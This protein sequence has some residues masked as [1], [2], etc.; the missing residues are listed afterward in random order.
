MPPPTSP[1]CAPSEPPIKNGMKIRGTLTI[2]D[3][4]QH[5]YEFRAQ[6]TTGESTQRVISKSGDA[7]LYETTGK[8]PMMVAHLTTRA[9]SSD[10]VSD[11]YD[12]LD[13]ISKTRD[14]GTSTRPP[15]SGRTLLAEENASVVLSKKERRVR[16]QLCIDLDKTPDYQNELIRLMQKISQCFLINQR[17]L[18]QQLN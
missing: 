9:D 16:M 2:V 13:K 7:K 10:P 4:D 11:L 18:R 12:Q 6:R 8:K 17:F 15:R 1:P 3:A 14:P 5:D